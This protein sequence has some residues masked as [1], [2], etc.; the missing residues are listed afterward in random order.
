MRG[1]RLV[2]DD[3]ERVRLLRRHSKSATVRFTT[4]SALIVAL[5]FM[6]CA[7]STTTREK[8]HAAF[9]RARLPI[10]LVHG[11]AGFPW[12]SGIPYFV[13]LPEALHARGDRVVTA[14]LPP[15]DDDH[16]RA[17]HLARTIDAIL[18]E[19]GAAKVHIIAHSQGGLDARHLLEHTPWAEKIATL[20]TLSTPHHG[21]PIADIAHVLLPDL[22]L[23]ATL[24]AHGLFIGSPD[25]VSFETPDGSAAVFA[26]TSEA[27]RER[28]ANAA[29]R[30]DVPI[31]SFAGVAGG[32]GDDVCARGHWGALR[33]RSAPQVTLM[34]TWAAI[35][36]AGGSAS[37][38]NDGLVPASSAVYGHFLGCLP[39]DHMELMGYGGLALRGEGTV[40]LDFVAFFTDYVERL[41][42]VEQTG[43]ALAML[44]APPPDIF[45]KD[46]TDVRFV[47]A[48]EGRRRRP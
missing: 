13:G 21:T 33:R 16:V 6:G 43:S 47:H 22:V 40:E 15:Y 5:V 34:A 37:L 20:T 25:D 36:L 17:A 48:L 31:F 18:N 42:D 10:V 7:S 1:A 30:A 38:A 32:G 23:D 45:T 35:H 8:T 39:A 28:N 26:L 29:L 46:G 41:H 27:R 24:G 14:A 11:I 3:D 19:T 2:T 4:W 12:A 44:D 9:S